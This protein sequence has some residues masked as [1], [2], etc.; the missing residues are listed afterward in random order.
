MKKTIV[1]IILIGSI[2][3]SCSKKS[4]PVITER[5]TEPAK[6]VTTNPALST[7]IAD[8]AMGKIVFTN[9]CGRCHELP[10]PDQFT[11]KR[12]EGILSYMMPKARL[13]QEQEVHVT[14]YVKANAIK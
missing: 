3:I 4:I 13:T 9:R 8:T 1:L 6:P 14:A 12:W 2:I 5:K 11:A 10:S 7:I